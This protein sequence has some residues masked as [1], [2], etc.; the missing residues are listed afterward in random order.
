[1]QQED[2][3]KQYFESE[4]V[5]RFWTDRQSKKS[6]RRQEKGKDQGD[7]FNGTYKLI[8]YF[9][10]D[11]GGIVT[12][13]QKY[14]IDVVTTTRRDANGMVYTQIDYYYNYSDMIPVKTNK[15][16]AI[17]WVEMIPIRQVTANYDPGTSFLA[18]QKG[19]DVFIFYNSSNEQDKMLEEEQVATKRQKMRD[20]IQR[21]ATIAKISTNG[22]LTFETVIDMRDERGV[23][24]NPVAMGVDKEN[25]KIIMINNTR[26]KRSRLVIV[27]Y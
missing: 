21:N 14:W 22:K 7:G 18:T 6:E 8:D 4:F 23:S 24:F 11:D 10:T 13:Y 9:S 3:N 19:Q 12:L 1:M 17:E 20:R 26:K 25:H 2:L 16:G 5:E 27:G 15:N